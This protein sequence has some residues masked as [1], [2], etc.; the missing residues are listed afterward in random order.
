MLDYYK[1]L[2][3]VPNATPEEIKKAYR[4]LAMMYHPD[5]NPDS[6]I[7][8]DFF[9]QLTEAYTILSNPEE[10]EKYNNN[11]NQRGEHHQ[12]YWGERNQTSQVTPQAILEVLKQI[13]YK[14]NG[15]DSS[16]INQTK[17]YNSLNDILSIEIINYLIINSNLNTNRQII[18]EVITCCK[19]LQY[20]YVNQLS[21]KLVKLAGAD[22][23]TTQ[24]IYS[25]NKKQKYMS[26]W[27]KYKRVI[28]L[29]ALI[30]FFVIY[31]NM[32]STSI[33][34]KSDNRQD[35]DLNNTFL[36]SRIEEVAKRIDE[37]TSSVSSDNS[38]AISTKNQDE[39]SEQILQKEKERLF[40]EG[41]E[42]SAVNNGQLPPCYNFNPKKSS[43]DNYLDVHVG[44]GTD[45]AIKVMNSETD[46][47]IRYVFINSGS[48][49]KIRNIPEGKYYLKIAYGKNWFSKIE[50]GQCKGKF[51]RNSL[52]EKGDDIMDFNLRQTSDGYD[53]PSFQLKLDVIATNTRNTFN[54]QKISENE[55]NN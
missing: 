11:F 43:I 39:I 26:Y 17:L 7:S 28:P 27:E 37:A 10:R 23:E 35:G 15:I 4:Q 44:G 32:N 48:T 3:V 2:G 36:D 46:E 14:V 42:E 13:S 19:S 30:L 22:N 38:Q 12:Q 1:I 6:K 31:S 55:F 9:K 18:Y 45:V 34:S 24:Q 52:Y 47:C 5:R 29:L 8:E 40:S 53:I 54:S 49:Y 16:R 51:I 21:T 41:W 33:S 20:A 25:F 50:D